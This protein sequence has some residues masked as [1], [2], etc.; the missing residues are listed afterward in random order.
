[1]TIKTNGLQGLDPGV[2]AARESRTF[3]KFA[4]A[5]SSLN[6]AATV[7]TTAGSFLN[8]EYGKRYIVACAYYAL[9]T[10]SD[11]AQFEI[12]TTTA[13]GGSGTVTARTPK[14]HS[15]T[16]ATITGSL[17]GPMPFSPPMAFTTD[18][19]ACVAMR[20][21]TNDAG[22]TVNCGFTGWEEEA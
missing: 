8:M 7:I 2:D 13:H 18:D 9:T 14:F 21:L 19:G 17:S 4:N 22:A 6:S 3:C 20:V 10:G 16:T 11:T 15:G 5:E 1:M 12:V